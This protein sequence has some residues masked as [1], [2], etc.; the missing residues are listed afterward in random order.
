MS[1]EAVGSGY[2]GAT[3]G[4]LC[5]SKPWSPSIMLE[6]STLQAVALLDM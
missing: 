2:A 1:E 6:A 5:P 3:A 4:T